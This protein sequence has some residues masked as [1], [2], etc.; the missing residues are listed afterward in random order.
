MCYFWRLLNYM[1]NC[2][3]SGVTILV[4]LLLR[5]EIQ[6]EQQLWTVVCCATPFRHRNHYVLVLV[7]RPSRRSISDHLTIHM[8]ACPSVLP[9]SRFPRTIL[10]MHGINCFEFGWLMFPGHLHDCLYLFRT[11]TMYL[12]QKYHTKMWLMYEAN[13]LHFCK[14]VCWSSWADIT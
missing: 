11:V 3:S 9:P 12:L 10:K 5:H 14:N 2:N 4:W 7:I 13:L 6:K 1:L 8:S